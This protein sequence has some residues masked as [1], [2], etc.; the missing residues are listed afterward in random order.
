MGR[1]EKEEDEVAE[2][3]KLEERRGGAEGRAGPG[4]GT[5]PAPRGGR[6][7]HDSV[8]GKMTKWFCGFPSVSAIPL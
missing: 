3:P 6:G 1:G 2:V 8:S 4:C 5:F 7:V